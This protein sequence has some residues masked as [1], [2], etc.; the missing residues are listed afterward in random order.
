MRTTL[1]L[2]FIIFFFFLFIFFILFLFSFSFVLFSCLFCFRVFVFID[3]SY[4]ITELLPKNN[5]LIGTQLGSLTTH[6]NSSYARPLK[7]ACGL[8]HSSLPLLDY[9]KTCD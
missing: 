8:K 5:N 4:V 7:H 6:N 2:A 1:G 3:L 9:Y